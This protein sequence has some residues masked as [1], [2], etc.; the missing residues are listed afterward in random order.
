MQSTLERTFL[1]Y[2]LQLG[3]RDNEPTIEYRFAPPRRWRFDFAW[4]REKVAV[5]CEG[6]VSA[7]SRHTTITGYTRDCDK[8]NA[9]QLEGWVVLRFTQ[10]HMED[11]HTMIAQVVEALCL[12]ENTPTP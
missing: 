6:I 10:L 9:A 5:E 8:Y 3:D 7:K 2:W 11:P 12:R 4:Q 1:T